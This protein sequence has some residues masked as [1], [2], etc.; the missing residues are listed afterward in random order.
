MRRIRN[1]SLFLLIAA[2]IC[3]CGG[4]G[5]IK[6]RGQVLKNGTP[7]QLGEAEGLR[8]V[9]VPYEAGESSFDVYPA[10]FEGDGNFTVVGKDGK[11]LPPGKYR[12]KLEHLKKKQ[13][14]FKGAFSGKK[15]PFVREV[16]TSS[17]KIVLDLDKPTS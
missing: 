10:V 4:D 13:D 6:A 11:G 9:F 15:T 17:N 16:T 12:V 5:R 3:G 7:F 8:I 14:L 1:G 2:F